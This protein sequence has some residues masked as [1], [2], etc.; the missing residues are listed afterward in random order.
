LIRRLEG[1]EVDGPHQESMGYYQD[2]YKVADDFIVDDTMLVTEE[3]VKI[4]LNDSKHCF[5]HGYCLA[6]A[7]LGKDVE[8]GEGDILE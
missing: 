8:W 2:E 1:I 7:L 6:M 4:M 5:G 3:T